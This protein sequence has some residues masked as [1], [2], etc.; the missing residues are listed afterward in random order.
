V[1]LRR[2]HHPPT[3]AALPLSGIALDQIA[4]L[5]KILRFS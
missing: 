1:A 5:V 3:W 2:I 4:S